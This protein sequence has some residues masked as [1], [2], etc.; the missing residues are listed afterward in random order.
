VAVAL[1][2]AATNAAGNQRYR[3]RSTTRNNQ[4]QTISSGFCGYPGR[5]QAYK[6]EHKIIQ[7]STQLFYI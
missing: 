2:V 3:R 6:Y 5:S 4:S 7:Y 1:R